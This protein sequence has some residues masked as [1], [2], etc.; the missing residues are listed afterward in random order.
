MVPEDSVVE[1]AESRKTSRPILTDRRLLACPK[2]GWVH[3]AMTPVE[4]AESDEELAYLSRRY[5]LSLEEQELYESA[6]R[7]CLRCES[8][9]DEFRAA[10]ER[11][12]GRAEGHSVTPVFVQPEV[13]TH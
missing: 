13:G 7:Q 12:L 8:S 11:D 5:E 6:Y 2:C 4:K 10:R 9:A 3:Y 1:D